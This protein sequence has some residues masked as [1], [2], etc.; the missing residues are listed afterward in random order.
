MIAQGY[1][2]EKVKK[3]G[4]FTSCFLDVKKEKF[5]EIMNMTKKCEPILIRSFVKEQPLAQESSA[6]KKPS[7]KYLYNGFYE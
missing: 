3:T 5:K 7:L 6:S 2:T 4:K 1:F